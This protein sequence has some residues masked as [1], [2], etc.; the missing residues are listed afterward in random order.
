MEVD[1]PLTLNDQDLM[2]EATPDGVGLAY[3]FKAQIM[4]GSGP[5]RQYR[6]EPMADAI[7]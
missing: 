1:G 2:V 7:G 4:T 5:S 3:A 6:E